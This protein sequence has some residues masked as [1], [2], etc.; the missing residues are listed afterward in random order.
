MIVWRSSC[1]SIYKQE[2]RVG[3]EEFLCTTTNNNAQTSK[4]LPKECG[5]KSQ[6]EDEEIGKWEGNRIHQQTYY[7]G[8]EM[9]SC[10]YCNLCT[11]NHPGATV[12]PC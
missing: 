11:S 2:I 6:M 7:T 12:L 9:H 10:D 1:W 5:T 3:M 8:I 4:I